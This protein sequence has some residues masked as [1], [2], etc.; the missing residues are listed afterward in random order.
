MNCPEYLL[1]YFN[2]LNRGN[3]ILLKDPG[4]S[5]KLQKKGK[6]AK[7]LEQKR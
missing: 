5:T 6:D 3:D 4:K 1:W 7:S 2:L